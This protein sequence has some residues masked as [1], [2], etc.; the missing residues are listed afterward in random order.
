MTAIA[1]AIQ[2]VLAIIALALIPAAVAADPGDIDAASRGVVRVVL[3]DSSG[4]EIAP[5]THGSGFAVAPNRIVTNAHVIREALLDDTIRIG[6]VPSEG[7]EATFGKPVA[8]SPRNDLALLEV[9]E[10]TLR[11]PPLSISGGVNTNL[12][13]VWSVGYPMNVDLAQGL[14]ISDIFRS[15]PPVKSRGF[16]SG[17]RPSRQFDTILHTAPIARGNSGGP[18]LDGCGRVI[19]VNSFGADS[20]GSDAE[21]YFAVSLRELLPFLRENEVEPRVNALPCRSIDELNLAERARLDA[22]RAQARERLE[23]REAQLRE[24]RAEARMRAQIEVM[25]ERDNAMAL[26]L[27]LLMAGAGACF[28]AAQYRQKLKSDP[29]LQTRAIVAAGVAGA[30]IIAAALVWITRPGFAEVEERV[31]AIL[32]DDEETQGPD[33]AGGDGGEDPPQVGA[34]AND[35]TL[36]CTLDPD[37]SRVTSART[38]DLAFEWAADGCVNERTQYAR[39][40]GEWIRVLVPDDEEAVAVNTYDPESRTFRSDRY[41]LSRSAMEDARKARRQYDIPSCGVTDA[42]R[43]LSEQQSALLAMLPERPNERLLYTCEPQRDGSVG[44]E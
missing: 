43:T 39:S 25:E 10:G 30:A 36:I 20:D 3:I 33:V 13:E 12:G 16:L 19:G 32:G 11:L 5:L 14:Q 4:E 23:A 8:V 28:V 27:V 34:S 31:A 22:E 37:R 42:A 9:S 38:D 29:A 21:F 7:D 1:R 15:Q 6:I 2:A 40:G 24:R 17:Q 26:A 35:G 44:G 41:L 18:L